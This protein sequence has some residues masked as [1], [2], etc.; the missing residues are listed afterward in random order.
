MSVTW[1]FEDGAAALEGLSLAIGVAVCEALEELGLLELKLKW[2]N[3]VLFKGRKLAGI[4]LEMVGD[5]AGPCQVVVGLGVNLKMP[6][7]S[8]QEINQEWTDIT[9]VPGGKKID[10]NKLQAALLNSLLPALQRFKSK[11]FSSFRERWVMRDAFVGQS[12]VVIIGERKISGHALGVDEHG[13]LLLGT[14][15]GVKKFNG[16]EVSLRVEK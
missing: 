13:A 12:V 8:G 1:T 6:A 9:N 2:P 15:E 11:G 3:D 7:K 10:R 16:G 4:L 14:A 5:A